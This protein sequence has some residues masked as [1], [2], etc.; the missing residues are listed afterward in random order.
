MRA[1]LGVRL[2]HH[3]T[4]CSTSTVVCSQS[5]TST[6]SHTTCSTV[7]AAAKAPA[8]GAAPGGAKPAA[9]AAAPAAAPVRLRGQL[10]CECSRQ[11]ESEAASAS[12]GAPLPSLLQ[13]ESLC[14]LCLQCDYSQSGVGYRGKP[15]CMRLGMRKRQM[16]SLR[17]TYDRAGVPLQGARG[18]APRPRHG[19]R[20]PWLQPLRQPSGPCSST[21]LTTCGRTSGRSTGPC[22]G[23]SPPSR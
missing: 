18:A 4:L 2:S 22:S 6:R 16:N 7:V 8:A 9:A 5:A 10:D 15:G 19:P 13:V 14:L 21:Y 11:F 1:L 23:A 20:R 12:A 17:R 3:G